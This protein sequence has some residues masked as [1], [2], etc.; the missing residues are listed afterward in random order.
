MTASGP[1]RLGPS[2]DQRDVEIALLSHR[3]GVLR[4]HV[5]RLRRSATDPA[6]RATLACI[7]S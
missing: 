2:A 6:I 7:Q 1:S 5:A 3:L 4:R